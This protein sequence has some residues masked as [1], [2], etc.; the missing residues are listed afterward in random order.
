MALFLL[1]VLVCFFAI[2]GFDHPVYPEKAIFSDN[3]ESYVSTYQL[4]KAYADWEDGAQLEISLENTQ[5]DG[6]GN[7]MRIKVLGPNP[8]DGQKSGSIYHSLPLFSRNWTDAA[9]VSFWIS[10]PSDDVLWLTFNFK[11]A[12]NEY[13]SVASGM[14]FLLS[15]K[16][17]AYIQS[18]CQYGNLVIPAQFTGK[19][20]IP[21]GSFSVPEWNT[22]R[23]DQILQTRSIESYAIGIAL[24]NDYPRVFY[25]DTF[26]VLRS[27][28]VP[29]AIDGEVVIR[30]PDSGEHLET[31]TV[32]IGFED[33]KV[34]GSWKVET[35]SN[36]GLSMD[37]SGVLTIPVGSVDEVIS[38]VFTSVENG[39]EKKVSLPVK[40][41][42]GKMT[43]A[44]SYGDE[45]TNAIPSEL[46]EKTEYE[47]FAA[48]FETWALE[49]RPL[50]VTISVF[51]V[52][53]VIYML[54][55]LQNRLK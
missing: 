13:W 43:P 49:H 47:Q 50:F 26:E 30:I 51:L 48:D 52:V 3:F 16:D 6:S 11:E 53:L 42:S 39:T 9:G 10:N 46:L 38:V 55:N 7:A 37:M 29:V 24:N 33:E 41:V 45:E 4:E 25:F 44:N 31:Y 36:P 1:A 35:L 21:L 8:Y 34:E 28:E 15:G 54:S 14:P 22:A 17:G 23:G 2:A 32:R 5:A 40:L 12:Y 18:Q 20:V 27:D 19:V